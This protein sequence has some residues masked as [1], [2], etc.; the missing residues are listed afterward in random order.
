MKLTITA[1]IALLA[2][3][4]PYSVAAAVLVAAFAFAWEPKR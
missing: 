3:G 2:I 1:I 4:S